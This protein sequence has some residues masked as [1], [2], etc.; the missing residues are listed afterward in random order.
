MTR[1]NKGQTVE[2]QPQLTLSWVA[3]AVKVTTFFMFSLSFTSSGLSRVG[4]S[5]FTAWFLAPTI[6]YPPPIR[7]EPFLCS[8]LRARALFTT[9]RKKSPQN[10]ELGKFS[11]KSRRL[12]KSKVSRRRR[13][14]QQRKTLS[15]HRI[16]L[17]LRSRLCRLSMKMII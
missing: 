16:S 17:S 6:T 7:C 10:G 4:K 12:S 3:R 5:I 9:S 8:E 13:L 11:N 14:A 1:L 15:I 2:W